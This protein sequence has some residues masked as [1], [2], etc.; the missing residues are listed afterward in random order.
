MN[1]YLLCLKVD[2]LCVNIN[3]CK[4]TLNDGTSAYRVKSSTNWYD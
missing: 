1:V 3:S 4:S 2:L